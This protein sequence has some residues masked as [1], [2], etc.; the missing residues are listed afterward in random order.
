MEASESSVVESPTEPVSAPVE[1]PVAPEVPVEQAPEAPVTTET[2][3]EASS[4][5]APFP[6]AEEPSQ[7]PVAP[8]MTPG[9]IEL[10]TG[11]VY[12]IQD[13]SACEDLS[14]QAGAGFQEFIRV[15]GKP[16]NI[17]LEEI[18]SYE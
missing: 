3:P 1:A 9:K 16:I 11:K 15:D 13:I 17:S 8:A 12:D 18:V 10:S 6:T 5:P 4:P 2:A 7:E 14:R